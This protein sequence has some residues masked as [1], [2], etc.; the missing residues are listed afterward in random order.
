M[1]NIRKPLVK[2][3]LPISRFGRHPSVRESRHHRR[4]W[5][6]SRGRSETPPACRHGNAARLFCCCFALFARSSLRQTFSLSGEKAPG[7]HY[8]LPPKRPAVP[9]AH[10][11]RPP[12]ARGWTAL[13]LCP[14]ER[15]RPRG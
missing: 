14:P 4:R 3:R 13:P 8:R 1:K 7:V 10:S 5:R 12:L 6:A 15:T 2:R 9:R 11:E